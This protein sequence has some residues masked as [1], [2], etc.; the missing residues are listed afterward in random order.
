MDSA[1]VR[2][3]TD[4]ITDTKLRE[5]KGI[6]GT[7]I[8][9]RVAALD[10]TGIEALAGLAADLGYVDRDGLIVGG[11][12][13]HLMMSLDP[14]SPNYR[15]TIQALETAG[16]A[17]VGEGYSSEDLTIHLDADVRETDIADGVEGK[18]SLCAFALALQR[19]VGPDQFVH[20]TGQKAYLN[21]HHC[22]LPP[23]AV[24]FIEVFD[25]RPGEIRPEPFKTHLVFVN[26]GLE[27]LPEEARCNYARF[28]EGEP[29]WSYVI[30]KDEGAVTGEIRAHNLLS[31][32]SK[33]TA[34]FPDDVG[35]DAELTSPGTF[36][37]PVWR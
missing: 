29:L 4:A 13:E 6:L 37:F 32:R 33:L 31:A 15:Q 36:T 18:C 14:D 5:L 34:A 19:A 7:A 2:I 35:A 8:V 10:W 28:I 21:T 16:K 9:S 23:E 3:F 25:H 22:W 1:G 20:V 17:R 12:S 27:A 30:E 24:R 26:T 11:L